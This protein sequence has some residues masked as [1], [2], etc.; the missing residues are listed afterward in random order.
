MLGL[1]NAL[2]ATHVGPQNEERCILINE[3]DS[4]SQKISDELYNIV[5]KRSYWDGVS[6]LVVRLYGGNS[7]FWTFDAALSK[8]ITLSQ[9]FAP[10][11]IG[12]DC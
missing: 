6:N 8:N 1:P 2:F 9:T 12:I 5:T 11:T 3:Q 4:Y 7:V 10:C